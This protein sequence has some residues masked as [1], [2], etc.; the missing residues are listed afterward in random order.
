MRRLTEVIK[1]LEDLEDV[2]DTNSSRVEWTDD[3]VS[4]E[5]D[6]MYGK[7]NEIKKDLES[8]K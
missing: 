4:M 1:K 6:W 7:V 5:M 8:M 3:E 2:L